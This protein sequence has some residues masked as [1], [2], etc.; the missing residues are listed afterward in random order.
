MIETDLTRSSI[1]LL[2]FIPF[3]GQ[4]IFVIHIDCR[5]CLPLPQAQQFG[6]GQ[7]SRQKK[8]TVLFNG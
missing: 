7:K 1:H 6:Y 5:L 8:S 3:K 2:P 4:S